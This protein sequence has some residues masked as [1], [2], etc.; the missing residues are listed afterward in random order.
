MWSLGVTII[1]VMTGKI[2]FPTANRNSWM[3][4]NAIISGPQPTLSKEGVSSEMYDFIHQCL[5]QP[6]KDKSCA[7][8][9]LDHPF[10]TLARDRGILPTHKPATLAKCGKLKPLDLPSNTSI[11]KVVEVAISWQLE[12]FEKKINLSREMPYKTNSGKNDPEMKSFKE[13][14]SFCNI[15][16]RKLSGWHPR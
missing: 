9:L 8:K 3:L 10:L 11:K 14:F 6:V 12:R 16:S 13:K 7:L 5:N 2:S 15:R 4:M 1:T